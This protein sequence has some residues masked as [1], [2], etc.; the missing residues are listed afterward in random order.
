MNELIKITEKDGDQLI[1]ARDLHESLQVGKDFSNWIKDRIEKYGFIEGEDFFKDSKSC[2]PNLASKIQNGWGGNNKLEYFLTL[3]MAKE[4]AMVENNEAG[5]EIRRYLI[6]VEKKF[7]EIAISGKIP[8][9]TE[10]KNELSEIR[11][12]LTDIKKGQLQI[13]AQPEITDPKTAM[14]YFGGKFLEITGKDG[15]YVE[16]QTLFKIFKGMFKVE[17]D[18]HKFM[19]ELPLAFPEIRLDTRRKYKALFRGCMIK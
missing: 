18:S 1:N 2:S 5:R 14:L 12:A 4:L 3:D 7:R 19:Y 16:V 13:S 8:M 6:K 17:I 10:L 15:N 11:K 9:H